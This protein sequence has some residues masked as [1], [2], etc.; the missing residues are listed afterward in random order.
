MGIISRTGDLFYTY[1]FIKTL[2][3][4]WNKTEAY[5]LGIIDENGKVLK[6]SKEL[7]TSAEK[8]AYTIFDRLVFN[9]KRL[10]E[11]V[12]L[13]K[14]MLGSYAAALFLIK[15]HSGISYD[16]LERV[17]VEEY[18]DDTSISNLNEQI[19]YR[20]FES[21]NGV[22]SPGTYFLTDNVNSVETGEL[23]MLKNQRVVINDFL[24]PHDNVIG[25]NIYE[26]YIENLS[27]NI[28][29]TSNNL[30]R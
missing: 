27:R 1:K 6:K 21:A 11:K 16:D 24:K 20:W 5:K 4:P 22:L 19:K 29:I 8:S 7:K 26:V 14:T 9:L 25:C 10:L 17:I 13:G 28:Y 23:I 3:T 30:T 2:T 12:P 15:E 18:G